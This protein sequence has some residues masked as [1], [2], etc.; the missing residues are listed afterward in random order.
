MFLVLLAG[1]TDIWSEIKPVTCRWRTSHVLPGLFPPLC[2]VDLEWSGGLVFMEMN[3]WRNQNL[4][5]LCCALRIKRGPGRAVALIVRQAWGGA[6][7]HAHALI[8]YTSTQVWGP[9]VQECRCRHAQSPSLSHTHTDL[10]F[11]MKN[12]PRCPLWCPSVFGPEGKSH[13]HTHLWWLCCSVNFQPKG[14]WVGIWSL[15]FL[16]FFSTTPSNLAPL[17]KHLSI[18]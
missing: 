12:V 17:Q 7:A 14:G 16:F 2:P 5:S 8:K 9:T 4:N 10:H 15:H 18:S 13:Y 3:G 11:R 6:P 1:I